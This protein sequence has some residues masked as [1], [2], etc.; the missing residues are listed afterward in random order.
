M[1]KHRTITVDG[2]DYRWVVGAGGDYTTKAVWINPVGR[3]KKVRALLGELAAD[4]N[5]ETVVAVTPQHV[6]DYI[7]ANKA[8][9]DTN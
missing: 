6:A 4:R 3:G 9:F 2:E 1:A 7:R 8:L 5:W